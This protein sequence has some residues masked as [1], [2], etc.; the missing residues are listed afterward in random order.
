MKPKA[1]AM[2]ALLVAVLGACTQSH[3]T[4]DDVAGYHTH[5]ITEITGI[6]AASILQRN[7]D[8]Q[9]LEAI[10]QFT[11]TNF[12]NLVIEVDLSWTAEEHRFRA[13]NTFIM[14]MLDWF[15]PPA[16]ACSLAPFYEDFEPRVSSVE[17][18]SDSDLNQAFPAGSDLSTVFKLT[19][20]PVIT[21]GAIYSA[22]EADPLSSRAYTFTPAL[23]NDALVA[24]PDTGVAHIFT[25]MLNLADGRTFEIR[26]N[27]VRINSA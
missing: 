11:G 19:P 4:C 13:T 23:T 18:F 10:D 3:D 20:A 12:S 15:I 25:I 9:G 5:T 1:F 22:I 26:T 21:D 24:I 6:D 8:T 16:H 17:I 7:P 14:S 2:M 27:E